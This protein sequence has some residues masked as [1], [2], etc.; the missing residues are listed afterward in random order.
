MHVDQH[1]AA[2]LEQV[3][4][5]R[6]RGEPRVGR[7]ID[8]P[9]LF[10]LV[11]LA[12]QIPATAQVELLPAARRGMF[13][14]R[15]DHLG[16]RKRLD[17]AG[18]VQTQV[19]HDDEADVIDREPRGVELR[20][21]VLI[22]LRLC[23]DE[24]G[25]DRPEI[26]RGVARDVAVQAGA[27]QHQAVPRVFDAETQDRERPAPRHTAAAIHEPVGQVERAGMEDVQPEPR[28]S[29]V[30]FRPVVQHRLDVRQPAPLLAC[31]AGQRQQADEH[32]RQPRPRTWQH[33]GKAGHVV[34]DFFRIS[35]PFPTTSRREAHAVS[36]SDKAPYFLPLSLALPHEGGGDRK[37]E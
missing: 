6:K 37:Q 15:N 25:A 19:G 8:E 7:E 22:R 32:V 28:L 4:A 31:T 24:G 21:H 34:G 36:H 11:E 3:V 13:L 12:R 10:D 5:P 17:L 9:P 33:S 27:D 14:A 35:L 18:V 20:D 29:R 2:V 30:V 1:D 26:A 23:P 16:L